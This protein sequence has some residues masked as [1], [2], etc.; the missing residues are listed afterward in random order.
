V[1]GRCETNNDDASQHHRSF[2]ANT[3]HLVL[4]TTPGGCQL[5]SGYLAEPD[6]ST[7]V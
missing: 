3:L 4:Q 1:N 2:E 6:C 7:G 5:C